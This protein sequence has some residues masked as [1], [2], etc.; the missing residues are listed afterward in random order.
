RQAHTLK[1]S[2]RIVN[3]ARVADLAHAMEE[4]LALYRETRTA[5]VPKEQIAQLL[6]QLDKISSELA[7]IAEAPG[8]ATDGGPSL[9]PSAQQHGT[10]EA[11]E[12]VRVEISEMDALLEMVSAA[13]VHIEQIAAGIVPVLKVEKLLSVL[14]EESI[15]N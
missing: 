6:R 9:P 15:S 14:A 2:A 5:A 1:G 10:I 7:A 13:A 12:R 8:N 4:V 3:L 11:F